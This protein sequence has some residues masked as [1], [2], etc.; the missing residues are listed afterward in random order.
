L[1]VTVPC[2][3][4]DQIERTEERNSIFQQRAERAGKLRVITMPDYPP[5][6]GD[7]ET[8]PVPGDTPLIR[9]HKRAKAD[10]CTNGD[11]HADPPIAGNGM[12]KLHEDA[13]RQ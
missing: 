12:M 2:D 11:D 9:A 13:C 8:K 10:T 7:T 3:F 1:K 4:C 6:A 5:I